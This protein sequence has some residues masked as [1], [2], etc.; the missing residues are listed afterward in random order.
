MAP[1]AQSVEAGTIIKLEI[2]ARMRNLQE[3][4]LQLQH[5]KYQNLIR[6][7]L[8]PALHPVET[9]CRPCYSSAEERISSN[10]WQTIRSKSGGK[11]PRI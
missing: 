11:T 10:C 4:S 5:R 3:N 1:G 8:R 6:G 2:A 7:S 9:A